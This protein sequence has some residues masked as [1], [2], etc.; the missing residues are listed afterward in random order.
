MR[1]FVFV[2]FGYRLRCNCISFDQFI[3]ANLIWMSTAIL[4]TTCPLLFEHSQISRNHIFPK[5]LFKPL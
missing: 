2:F 1:A 4:I 5:R 3:L